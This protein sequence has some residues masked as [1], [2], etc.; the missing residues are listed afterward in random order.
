MLTTAVEKAV[1]ELRNE[2]GEAAV[3]V[4]E[5]GSG[6]AYVCIDNIAL[7]SPPYNSPTWIAF[8]LAYTHPSADIYPV[9]VRHDLFQDG[10]YRPAMT[11]YP[12]YRG[13][14]ATQLSRG[15]RRYELNPEYDTAA[16]K[17]RKVVA[18]LKEFV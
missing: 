12:D 8:Q 4:S 11:D 1:T 18:W 2:F 3:S 10:S 13:R 17:I 5:D 9:Y 16:A 14:H 15:V 7:P 6:G